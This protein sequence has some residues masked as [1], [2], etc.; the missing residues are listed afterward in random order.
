MQCTPT[1]IST[2]TIQQIFVDQQMYMNH[3]NCP[4]DGKWEI[5][6]LWEILIDGNVSWYTH[7]VHVYEVVGHSTRIN[8]KNISK[9]KFSY[10][11]FKNTS[12]TGRVP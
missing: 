10:E 5:K 12:T 7:L 3:T 6:E 9:P 1:P 8:I 11:N 4:D 2:P